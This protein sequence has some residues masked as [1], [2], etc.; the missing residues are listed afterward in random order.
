MLYEYET[1]K[2]VEKAFDISEI[3]WSALKNCFKR[4]L[5]T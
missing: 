4:R 2:N 1:Q 3:I 5:T